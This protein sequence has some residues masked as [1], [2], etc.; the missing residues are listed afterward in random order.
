MISFEN[1]ILA[2]CNVA[3]TLK[4]IQNQKPSVASDIAV[5]N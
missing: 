3:V 5:L 4:G 1:E 2:I